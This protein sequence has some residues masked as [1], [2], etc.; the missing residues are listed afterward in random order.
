MWGGSLISLRVLITDDQP[1]ARTGLRTILDLEPGIDVVGEA[2]NGREAVTAAVRLRPDLVI[3]DLQ[4]PGGDGITAIRELRAGAGEGPPRVLVLTTFSDD[5]SV[6]A[7]LQAGAGGFLLK[8]ASPARLLDA[9]RVVSSGEGLLD[10][11]VTSRV[12][13]AGA[14]RP[15]QVREPEG[16]EDLT[17]REREIFFLIAAGHSNAAMADELQ[18]GLETVRTHVKHVLFKL[19]LRDRVHLVV[20]AYESGLVRP[21]SEA[22]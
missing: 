7:A 18:L 20:A 5:E 11:A 1:L 13:A 14:G 3:M 12:I 22:S 10:P 17:P 6:F 16:F 2:A 8:D 9:I 21:H 4:M 19:G 15:A